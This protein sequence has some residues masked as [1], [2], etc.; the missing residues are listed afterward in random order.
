MDNNVP[1]NEEKV[2]KQVTLKEYFLNEYKVIK[3]RFIDGNN[4]AT[5]IFGWTGFACMIMMFLY[6]IYQMFTH[7]KQIY[8]AGSAAYGAANRM[9]HSAMEGARGVGRSVNSVGHSAMQGVRGVGNT[10]SNTYNKGLDKYHQFQ[11]NQAKAQ[12]NRAN[13]AMGQYGKYSNLQ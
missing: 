10:M 13:Q 1:K 3:E 11:Y 5:T 7:K 8:D 9:G 4:M 2:E 6:I 12:L